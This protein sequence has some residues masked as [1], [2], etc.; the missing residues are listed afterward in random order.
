MKMETDSLTSGRFW[1]MLGGHLVLEKCRAVGNP[2]IKFVDGMVPCLIYVILHCLL[3]SLHWSNLLY[4]FVI[5]FQNK[6]F[7]LHDDAGKEMLE[8]ASS[9]G[10]RDATFAL[11]MLMLA[12]GKGMKKQALQLLSDAYPRSSPRTHIIKQTM[13]KVERILARDT[14]R[15]IRFHGCL[16]TCTKH[17][18][19]RDQG[20]AMGYKWLFECDVC[21]WEACF[22]RF[23]RIFGKDYGDRFR[24]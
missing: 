19:G 23:G 8:E 3:I 22:M 14:R 18:S 21:L 12:E 13:L 11:G 2:N 9:A 4:M 1:G 5:V 20:F 15:E 7:Y 24:L 17:R 10:Q 16:L 6:Y